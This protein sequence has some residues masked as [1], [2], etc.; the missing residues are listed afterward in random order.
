MERYAIGIDVGGTKI[1]YGVY[2]SERKLVMKS[3]G[4]SDPKLSPEAFFDGIGEEIRRLAGELGCAV[5]DLRGVGVGMPSFVNFEDGYI[6]KTT[7][8]TKIKDFPARDYLKR[9]LGADFP[10]ILDND[11]HTG[12]LAEYRYGAGQGF[13]H[14]LYC[15]VST[16]ISSG[17]IVDGRLFR[18]R[19]GWA[20]ES[21]H[22]ILTPGQGIE[23]GCGNRGCAMSWCSGSMVVKHIRS[24]IDE[25]QSSAMVD[26]AGGAE[27]IS[28]EHVNAAW[29]QGDEMARRAVEQMA[30]AMATWFFNLYVILNINCFVLGGGLLGMGEKLFGRMRQIFDDYNQNDYPVY[31]KTAEL[32]VD[33]ATIGAVEL[34]YD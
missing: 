8:L 13:D 34:L 5:Q 3:R 12:A 1:A 14:M 9:E 22:M 7:N 29:E 2:D 10:I 24:W 21:G 11:S 20:G 15:P 28:T 31:F 25:G 27:M 32:S 18:G 26:L 23:C 17:I 19:Y 16:G 30:N 6:L 33:A 4:R